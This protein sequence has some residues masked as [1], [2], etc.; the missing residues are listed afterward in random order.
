MSIFDLIFIGCFLGTIGT[1][2]WIT[3]LLLRRRFTDARR[4]S[5]RLGTLVGLYLF[6]VFLVGRSSARRIVASDEQL[7]YDDWC[8]GV[9]KAALTGALSDTCPE[10]GRRFLVITLKVTSTAGR[11]QAAPRGALVYLIDEAANR[12]DVSERAQAAFE[13]LNGAQPE[14]AAKLDP[15]DSFL[16]SRVFE[17]PIA[18]REFFLGHRHGSG[19]WFPEMLIIGT[20]FSP[21][22]VIRLQVNRGK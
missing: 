19:S 15:R 5:I 6:V 18:G 10:A 2:V 16:T 4:H 1:G 9:Q 7:R 13:K 17:V 20:G 11:A 12:Y 3:G 21:A 8:L 14:L 22:P